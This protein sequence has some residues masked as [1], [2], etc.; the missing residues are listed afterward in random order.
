MYLR[1]TLTERWPVCFMIDRSLLPALAAPVAS[2]ALITMP[3]R[4][5]WRAERAR[6]LLDL[7]DAWITL[8]KL[9]QDIGEPLLKAIGNG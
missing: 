9:R 2:P 4:T 1:T 7:F 6:P 5:Q 8:H 3:E